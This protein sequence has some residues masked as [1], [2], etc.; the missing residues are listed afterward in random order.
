ME[1]TPRESKERWADL[2]IYNRPPMAERLSGL[3]LEYQVLEA[4]SHDRGQRSAKISFHVG[5]GSQDIG[6]RNE[7]LVLF[8]IK[9]RAHHFT[10]QRREWQPGDGRFHHQGSRRQ[11]ISESLEAFGARF[12]FQPQVYRA[13]R[14]T[15][16]L[17]AG[18]YTIEYSAGPEYFTRT[19]ELNID[20]SGP[21]EL[22]F[23][24]QRWIDPSKYGW[25]SGDHHI[26]AAGCSHYKNPTEGVE[27]KDMMRQVLGESLNIGAVLT[28]GPSWYYQKKFFSA[29][30]DAVSKPNGSCTTTWRF[31]D[32]LQ[33]CRPLVLMGL[34]ED[35]YPGTTRIE[36]WP[37]LGSADSSLGQ[38]AGRGR[39]LLAF[40]AGGWTYSARSSPVTK[41]PA[42]IAS[43]PTNTSLM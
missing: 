12:S 3:G 34:K 27:P 2:A 41:C 7:I 39:G 6:F 14:E 8:N 25:W 21:G 35:D 19:K 43:A 16:R 22:S 13:D 10:R 37:S 30:D 18:Y 23:Q 17:P 42:S 38:G 33:P 11:A 5:Q 29:A 9:R 4:Y 24:L 32:F 15:V 26:H 1:L 36:E 31:R 20:E 28:W 40:G